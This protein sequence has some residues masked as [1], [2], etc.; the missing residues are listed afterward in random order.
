MTLIESNVIGRS[1]SQNFY[2]MSLTRLD[3]KYVCDLFEEVKLKLRQIVNK[4]DMSRE[5]DNVYRLKSLLIDD[6]LT[7]WLI[8]TSIC[9]WNPNNDLVTARLHFR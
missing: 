5:R 6:L 4:K 9:V 2:E 3:R 7:Q 8:E 1:P